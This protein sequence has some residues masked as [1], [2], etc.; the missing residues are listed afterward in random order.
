MSAPT[1]L[2]AAEHAAALAS[3]RPR[4]DAWRHGGFD[5]L[6]GSVMG[7]VFDAMGASFA[8]TDARL[9]DLV[10]E[11]FC[12]T[13]IETR[14]LWAL[15]HGLPDGCDP[16]A[17]PCEKANAVGDSTT[18]YAIAAA[19]RRGWSITIAQEFVTAAQDGGC[20][21]MLAGAGLCAGQQGVLWRVTVNLTLSPAYVARASRPPLAGLMLAGDAIACDA[22]ILALVCLVRRIA[23]AHADL[24]FATISPPAPLSPS[25]GSS[26]DFSVPDNS[27]LIALL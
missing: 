25:A 3:L 10:D 19:Q 11:F 24:D 20:G 27:A 17:D 16:F 22:D 21:V 12:S 4:G 9:C 15:E 18:D 23:P 2:S 1:C 6:P 13:A 14:D 5:G 26:L 8:R 7:R